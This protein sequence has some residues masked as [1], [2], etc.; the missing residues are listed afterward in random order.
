LAQE[1][2]IEVDSLV[3]L[4]DD[5][6]ESCG[7]GVAAEYVE[8]SRGAPV[9]YCFDVTN[10]GNS[11]LDSVI[12]SDETL[13]F[14]DNSTGKLAPG[15]SVTV[16]F[17]TTIDGDLT[18][19]VVVTAKPIPEDGSAIPVVDT[20]SD[21]GSSTVSEIP[22][23]MMDTKPSDHQP[24]VQ[25]KNTVY[26]G[27]DLGAA[28]GRFDVEMVQNKQ[29][30][31]VIYC[32]NVTNTGNTYLKG[33]TIKDDELGGFFDNSIGSLAPGASQLVTVQSKIDGSLINKALV[34]ATPDLRDGANGS[35][36]ADV[37]Y[38]DQSEVV[39]D[40]IRDG[41]IKRGDKGP[42]APPYNDLDGC[43]QDKWADAGISAE[44]LICTAEDAFLETVASDVPQG[45]VVGD[46]VSI[47]IDASIMVGSSVYDLGWYIATDGGDALEG[48]CV[49]NGLQ[50]RNAYSVLDQTSTATAGAVVWDDGDECGDVVGVGSGGA[51][52]AI[53]FAVEL[54]VPCTDENED[55]VLDF[56][57][58][59]TWRT[60]ETNGSC[61]FVQNI[62]A[63]PTGG[64]FC[65]RY[66]VSNIAVNKVA[67]DAAVLPCR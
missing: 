54:T 62:P 35:V 12:I 20:V 30:T 24:S 66:D 51:H 37:T 27:D 65:T 2:K 26:L 23:I 41:N 29:G 16:A 6:G 44:P 32:F 1:A 13:S 15:E 58:C 31:P 50:Q 5:N 60:E 49:K 52:I 11:S 64:C 10:T 3:Y 45:C 59:F 34:T 42:Y 9:T 55:G 63:T 7:T 18:N 48:T 17:A 25:I 47:T 28:C 21:T 43:L 22:E 46:L 56:A 39:E 33:I 4:G 14:S 8:G 19:K 40:G 67:A 38:I 57:V 53:P 36:I 61:S